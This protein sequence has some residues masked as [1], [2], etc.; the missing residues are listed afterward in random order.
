VIGSYPG[1]APVGQNWD[2]Q[3]LLFP[4]SVFLDGRALGIN[5]VVRQK[6]FISRN[7]DLLPADAA[8]SAYGALPPQ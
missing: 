6:A 2:E 5:L 1:S 4:W 8:K 3:H 7:E